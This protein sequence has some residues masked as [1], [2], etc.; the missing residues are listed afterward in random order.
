MVTTQ[1]LDQTAVE[2]F[3]GQV[4]GW[5]N[6]AAI[7]QALSIGHHTGLLDT[8][9]GLP[10]STSEQIAEAAGLNERY[11]REWL[12]TLVTGGIVDY[13][14]ERRTY[15][16]PPERA[17]AIT[18]AAGPNNLAVFAAFMPQIALVEDRIIDAFRNGGGV[19]YSGFPQFQA[20]MAEF[21]GQVFDATL[22]DVVVPL[23]PGLRERLDAG[24]DV[25]DIGCGSGHA[26]NI[27]AR[28]FPNSRFV[29]Y[30]FSPEGI[31]A[32][33]A[34]AKDWGLTNAAFVERDVAQ[35]D[36]EA[37]YD[38]ITIF[39]AIHDQAQ[40]RRVLKKIAQALRSGGTFLAVDVQAS[41][42][43]EDNLAHPLAP[44]LYAFSTMH[45]MTVSL[46]LGGEGLGAMWGAQQACELLAEAGFV[47]QDVKQVP[48]DITNNYY[49]CT[50]V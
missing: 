6:G 5:L 35:L 24:I 11:V 31:A 40:P 17:A 44:V 50:K 23:V 26:L 25:A 28:A 32:A 15:R 27:L 47:V 22:L 19:P 16:L 9:A 42:N 30:D 33:H 13:D 43:L 10:P 38:F 2:Q 20:M 36:V 46:A 12:G 49:V 1:E 45:C 7:V 4:V 21:S 37:A 18:R 34:E 8:L 48:G 29:G 14:P 41:S 3:A 39:D